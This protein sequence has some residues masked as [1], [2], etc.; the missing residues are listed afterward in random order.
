MDRHGKIDSGAG[1]NSYAPIGQEMAPSLARLIA[2]ANLRTFYEDP[3]NLSEIL[4]L[5]SQ[6]IAAKSIELLSI[7]V[8]DTALLRATSPELDRFWTHSKLFQQIISG[9]D[10]GANIDPEDIL[11]ARLITAR[12]AYGMQRDPEADGDPSLNAIANAVCTLLNRP[13][14][15]ARYIQTELECEI[16]NVSLNP[17]VTALEERFPSLPIVFLSDMYLDSSQIGRIFSALKASEKRPRIFSSAD[18]HG[19]KAAGALFGHVARTMHVAPGH[20]LHIG[21]NL[22]DDY[23]S[24]KR[25]GWNALYLPLPGEEL[26][27]RRD[28]FAETLARIPVL[29][30]GFRQECR[31]TP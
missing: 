25:S 27:T 5:I 28:C 19:S 22:E 8:F 1:R 24:A 26:D 20:A 6:I 17:L 15:A 2:S 23:R 13:D 12:A 18:G 4:D 3:E 7:D 16:E 9:S 30:S 11:L 29:E 21:D 14:L 10:A 31:F